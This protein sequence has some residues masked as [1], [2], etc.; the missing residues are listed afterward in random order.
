[1]SRVAKAPVD[2]VSG[3]EI[4]IAGQDVTVKGKNGTLTRHFNEAVEVVQEENQLKALPREGFANAW[5]QAGTVRA[6]LN[7][8]IHGVTEGFEKKLQLNGVGYRA[9]AQGTK[10][11][12][13][14]GFSHPVV[15]E[16]PEGITVETPSQTEIVVKGA[17][18]Q[19]VGQV[20]ANIRAYR[21]PEPYKGK[22]VRYADEHVRRKE[23][24]KK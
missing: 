23:A 24:K 22:G 3:V 10:L 16:M 18:K 5:A 7:M 14:L 20:A 1:M 9:Q 8:M 12:L 11:N 17:D 2:V 19:V 4:T 21:P 13:T 6:L 15:Y